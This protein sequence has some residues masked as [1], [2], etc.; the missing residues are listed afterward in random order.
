MSGLYNGKDFRHI[1]D[2]ANLDPD[3]VHSR[4]KVTIK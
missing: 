4:Y 2:L 3:H 1:C